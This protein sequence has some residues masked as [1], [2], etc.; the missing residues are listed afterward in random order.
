MEGTPQLTNQM[1]DLLEG[2]LDN[3][4]A[5]ATQ[6]AANGGPLD[7]LAASMTISVDTV[8]RQKQEI[9]R[10]SEKLSGLKKKGSSVTSGDTVPGGNNNVC[11]HCEAVGQTALHR[12]KLCYF[13][14]QKM[15]DRKDW[16][17]RLMEEKGVKFRDDELR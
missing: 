17:R 16:S 12:K 4:A 15:P 7:E 3:I 8:S 6:T 5:A 10:L 1:L 2:Y 14:P 9:K 13:D 11:K